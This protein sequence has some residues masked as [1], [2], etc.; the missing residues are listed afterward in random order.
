MVTVQVSSG[1]HQMQGVH[2]FHIFLELHNVCQAVEPHVRQLQASDQERASIVREPL[3]GTWL[4]NHSKR[5]GLQLSSRGLHGSI[6]L[7]TEMEF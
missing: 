1:K 4:Q 3:T 5:A 2:I 6:G 7:L